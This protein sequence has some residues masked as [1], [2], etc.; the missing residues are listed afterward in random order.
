MT[1]PFDPVTRRTLVEGVRARLQRSIETAELAPGQP[2]PSE[3]LLSQ[4]L[5]VGRT[6][7]REAIQGLVTLG[8]VERRGNRTYVAEQFPAVQQARLDPR[9][10][11]VREVFEVRRLIE[12]P[13]AELAAGRA[14]DDE[15]AEIDRLARLFTAGA[16]LSDFR[17]LDRH[18]HWTVAH[19]CHN[20]VLAEIYL[21]VL[22]A[23]FTSE[24]FRSLLSAEHNRRAVEKIV[25][26]AGH[27]HLLIAEAVV[28]ADPA[29][30][31]A[32]AAHLHQVE[33]RMLSQLG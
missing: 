16:E 2:L 12:V 5:Q 9:K 26:E 25:A 8:L 18:F 32:A 6:S 10:A 29:A 11:R 19:A 27:G 23:L 15:R 3:R 31:G 33:Q 7:V 30:A 20:D 17:A 4:G 1:A 28:R 13:V 21:K 14:T 22:D 24:E